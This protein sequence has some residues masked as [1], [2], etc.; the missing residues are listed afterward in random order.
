MVELQIPPT[1]ENSKLGIL[2][3]CMARYSAKVFVKDAWPN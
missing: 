1:A 2:L 3:H